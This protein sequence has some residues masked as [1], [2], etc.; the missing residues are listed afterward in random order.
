MSVRFDAQGERSE[1]N[2]NS[3]PFRVNRPPMPP[4][5]ARHDTSD[6]FSAWVPQGQLVLHLA[7]GMAVDSAG[8]LLACAL[9][10]RLCHLPASRQSS[11]DFHRPHQTCLVA[12]QAFLFLAG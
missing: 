6:V 12:R 3:P 5:P 7:M 9:T 4:R 11:L 2:R 8:C 10:L 1:K